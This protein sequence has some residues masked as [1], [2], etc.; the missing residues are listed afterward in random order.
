MSNCLADQIEFCRLHALCTRTSRSLYR[1]SVA[2]TEH[3][4]KRHLLAFWS[5]LMNLKSNNNMLVPDMFLNSEQAN[6]AP[7]MAWL[8]NK[9]FKSFFT[10]S[11]LRRYHSPTARHVMHV[12]IH[13]FGCRPVIAPLT[14]VSPGVYERSTRLFL[15]RRGFCAMPMMHKYLLLLRI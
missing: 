2:F 5:F 4:I 11:T 8:F 3:N 10:S 14:D 1:D 15:L 9:H 12:H 7:D 13:Q 6:C